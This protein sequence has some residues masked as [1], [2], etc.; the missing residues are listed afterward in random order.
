M[1]KWVL[2]LLLP[3]ALACSGCWDQIEVEER[4]YVLGIAIDL[5][6]KEKAERKITVAMPLVREVGAA[7]TGGGGG[8]KVPITTF[9][10]TAP[11]IEEA[12]S[13]I[14]NRM[15]RT[16]F[17]GHQKVLIFS[18][19]SARYPLSPWLDFFE[20]FSTISRTALIM[21]SKGEAS[22]ALST[23]PA[24]EQLPPLYLHQL[25]EDTAK[26]G[27]GP[28][29]TLNNLACYFESRAPGILLPIIKTDKD[30]IEVDGSAVLKSN[31]LVGT[32]KKHET[33]GA[34]WVTGEVGGGVIVLPKGKG[35]NKLSFQISNSRRQINAHYF[36][37]GITFKV[38]VAVEGTVEEYFGSRNVMNP[39]ILEQTEKEIGRVIK[40]EIKKAIKKLQ[41]DLRTDALGLGV[42]VRKRN[43]KRWQQIGDWN[44]YFAEQV[45]IEV[46]DL[47]VFI[48]RTGVLR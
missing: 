47:T 12:L 16:L 11:T 20:R 35:L 38:K 45:K 24:S 33:R 6:K 5:P 13:P 34:L 32:L 48:R 40:E 18:E 7:G 15:N 25:L 23:A 2:S 26:F 17:F 21:V 14:Q 36:E 42:M 10:A 39:K 19:E 30:Y 46:T 37:D 9:A 27:F 41:K 4:A 43:P 44:D 31:K 28:H 8:N 22:K 3:L 29:R 1:R